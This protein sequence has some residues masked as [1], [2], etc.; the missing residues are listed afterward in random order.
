V[1]KNRKENVNVEILV[2]REKCSLRSIRRKDFEYF[3]TIIAYLF[4][5]KNL[6]Y[7][8]AVVRVP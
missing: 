8:E 6:A 3:L 1:I 4:D 5:T 7:T 2:K